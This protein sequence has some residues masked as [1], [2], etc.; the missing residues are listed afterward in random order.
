MIDRAQHEI[1][2]GKFLS[3]HDPE[4]IWG[5]G[6]LAGQH[7]AQRRA[8]LLIKATDMNKNSTILEIG[9]G[10]GMF[11]QMFART[12]AQ[13]TAVDISPELIERAKKRVNLPSHVRFLEK[14]FED[15]EVDG[16][17]DIVIGSSILHHLE[18]ETAL[19]SMQTK[20][21]SCVGFSTD[22]LVRI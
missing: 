1:E 13:I 11:T 17:F 22:I 9:C 6:T 12:N 4:W 8:D 14:R 7:R 5:W 16:P 15:C 10:T 18:V 19:I 20:W 2:H 21:D 3:A